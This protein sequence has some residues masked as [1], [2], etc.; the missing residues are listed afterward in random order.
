MSGALC[1]GGYVRSPVC[2]GCY[3]DI[4][5]SLVAVAVAAAT[6]AAVVLIPDV[7]PLHRLYS[8]LP[9]SAPSLER[10][11]YKHD[12]QLFFS[13]LHLI[14]LRSIVTHFQN[15]LRQISSRITANLTPLISS[16]TE[17]LIIGLK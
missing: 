13:F 16:K 17:F 12:A 6:E 14:C 10:H 5:M 11:L 15:I 2:I 9:L 4:L 3:H 1:P 8:T 7:G